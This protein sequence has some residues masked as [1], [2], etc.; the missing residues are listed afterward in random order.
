ML[1]PMSSATAQ[2]RCATSPQEPSNRRSSARKTL[3]E[4]PLWSTE[5]KPRRPPPKLR[6]KPL[7]TTLTGLLQNRPPE[8]ELEQRRMLRANQ[9]GNQRR[10][11]P[12]AH[13]RL[14]HLRPPRILRC[15]HRR[16]P[17]F[18]PLQIQPC[19]RRRIP[20]PLFIQLHLLL[21][22]RRSLLPSRRP[23]LPIPHRPNRRL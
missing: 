22:S 11:N 1:G 2:S 19:M 20:Q 8:P 10:Q 21:R 16:T 5:K 23:P 18:T 4:T 14:R 15:R 6:K 9:M 3:A 12:K 13:P 17:P 7:R